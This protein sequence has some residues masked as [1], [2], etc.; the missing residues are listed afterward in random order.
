VLEPPPL[1]RRALALAKRLGFE[2]SCSPQTGRL[3]HV[4]AAQRGRGRAGEIGTGCGV[5]AAWI[6]AGLAPSVPFVTVERDT[7]LAAAARE[8]LSG[9]ANALVLDGDWR[10]FLAAEAPFDLL[11]VD[12]RDAK[13]DPDVVGLLAPGGTA[14]LDD[15]R[16]GRPMA[17]PVRELWLDHPE[18]A[19]IEVA[20]SERE[21]VILA[22]RIL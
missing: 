17:Y 9:D 1:V 22:T 8:L 3:L 21:A 12:A 10:D 2:R 7:R 4:L 16:P 14:I 18:L 19:A 11:F 6:L 13:T 5:G 15:L 20:V